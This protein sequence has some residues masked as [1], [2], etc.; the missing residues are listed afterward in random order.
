MKAPPPVERKLDMAKQAR[1]QPAASDETTGP[2]EAG[3]TSVS[4][5]AFG[6]D[7]IVER[8]EMDLR[9]IA[10][11]RQRH[12]V[13]WLDVA[14]S[15]DTRLLTAIGEEFG[16]HELALEDAVEADQRPKVEEY[17]DHLFIVASALEG[18]G[19]LRARQ[20][21]FFIGEGFL[22]TVREETVDS[23]ES[24]RKRLRRPKSRIRHS[25]SDYLCYALL[26]AIVDG[27]FP[28]LE[29]IG[30]TLDALEDRVLATPDNRDISDIH[31]LKRGLLQIRRAIWPHREL[32]NTLIRDEHPLIAPETTP[33]LR[34]CYDH[35]V[36]IIDIV[37]TYREIASELV[38]VHISS[39]SV[40]INEVMKVLTIV[41]TIFIPLSFIASVYGMNFDRD[42]SPWNMPELGWSLGYPFALL[43][44]CATAAGL[45]WYIWKK[46]WLR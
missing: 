41:A 42:S 36:Q 12:R 6:S 16:L 20:I 22:V 11:L 5:M 24:V 35:T 30:E 4:V 40:K 46:G 26:D 45:I 32:F 31:D 43:L 23:F 19:P 14:Q 34:D 25:G 3:R 33:F 28:V 27:Y 2:E 9:A 38:D 13:I 37:E 21:A 7:E 18:N 10:D 15:V 44:M 17:D 29:Q 8:T 1:R 39:V